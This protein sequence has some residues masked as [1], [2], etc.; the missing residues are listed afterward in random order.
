MKILLVHQSRIPVF[1]YGGTERVIWDL[2][3][4]LAALGHQVTFLVP[5][6]SSCPFARVLFMDPQRTLLEQVPYHDFDIVHFQCNID[7]E[8]GYPYL[9]SE[10]GNSK[11]SL[12]LPLNTV[13]VSRDH[14]L[15][16]GSGSFV[17][18]GLDWDSHAPVD[19]QRKREYFHFLGKGSWS[20]KNLQGAIRIARRAQVRLEVLGGN[21]LNISRGFRFTPW[22]SIH[23]NGMV[24]G[25]KKSSILNGSSGMIFPV[26]WHE[27]F[28]LAVIESLYSGAPV[29]ATPYGALPEIVTPTCGFLSAS[30]RDLANAV[31]EHAI[32]PGFDPLAC[33][34]RARDDFNHMQM[35]MGY[36][37]RYQRIVHGEKLN[38]TA[39]QLLYNGHALLDWTI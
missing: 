35:A 8:P 25:A 10:H 36:A 1:A 12:P 3:K 39:P 16:H 27:P 4:G 32:H 20:V 17:Y 24:G 26:R 7:P 29:F 34:Q 28:G 6:G 37:A 14:A 33:H 15:R 18:N 23:F 2:A 38:V 19:W 21:R 11:K 31:I 13:F 5:E 22:P 9:V 30:G